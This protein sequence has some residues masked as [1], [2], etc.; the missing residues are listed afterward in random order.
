MQS[1]YVQL[2]QSIRHA[3]AVDCAGLMYHLK[4][5]S[6]QEC[7]NSPQELCCCGGAAIPHVAITYNAATRARC[8]IVCMLVCA[9]SVHTNT[10]PQTSMDLS[11]DHCAFLLLGVHFRRH[12]IAYK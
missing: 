1:L 3:V 12:L 8:T 7:V 10:L 4:F 2:L 6:P 5:Y 11:A 9:A